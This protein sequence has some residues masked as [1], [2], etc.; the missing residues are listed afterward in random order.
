MLGVDADTGGLLGLAA[1]RIWTRE[2]RVK[3]P[4]HL[5]PL[6]QKESHR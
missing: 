2:E 1:G 5:R 4:H 3:T 6:A